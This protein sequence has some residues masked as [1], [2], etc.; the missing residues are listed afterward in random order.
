VG[1][2]QHGGDHAVLE[3]ESLDCVDDPA[4]HLQLILRDL[5]R[6]FAVVLE[7]LCGLYASNHNK[8]L[9]EPAKISS[10]QRAGEYEDAS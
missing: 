9:F 2:R 3:R 8:G 5:L 4:R 1:I 7:V 10:E 6:L